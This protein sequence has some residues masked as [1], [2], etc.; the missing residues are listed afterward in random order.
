MAWRDTRASRR[1]LLLFSTSIVMGIAA[2][3]AIRSFAVSAERAI[4]EQSRLLLGA[5]LS[6]TS[7][8][9]L[10]A[11]D[12]QLLASLGGEQAREIDFSAMLYFP[13][14]AGAQAGV[15][16]VQV[17][18]SST[19]YPFYGQF[20]AEPEGAVRAFR[21][22][23]GVLLEPSLLHQFN[24]R[25]GDAVRLGELTTR[26]A[27]TIKR[28]PGE[29]AA[30]AALAPRV[31]VSTNLVAETGLLRDGSI[32]RYKAYF[33]FPEGTKVREMVANVRPELR[34]H[35][36]NFHTVETRKADLGRS[37]DNVSNY[38]H[39]AAL[40]ALLLGGIGVASGIHVHVKAKLET[41]AVL[42][43]LGC[44]VGQ[45]FAIYLCQALLV[46]L[47]GALAGAAAGVLLQHAVPLAVGGFFPVK[48]EVA[49]DWAGVALAITQGLA[50]AILFALLPLL[51]VRRVSPLAAIR[52]NY[53]PARP[54]HH[55]WTVWVIYAVMTAAVVLF[56]IQHSRGWKQ[57]LQFAGGLATAFLV[58]A[59]VARAIVWVARRFSFRR[60]PYVWRQGFANLHRPQN[61]TTLLV[62]SLGLGTFLILSIFLVQNSLVKELISARGRNAP[63]L[64]LFD[65][66]TDQRDG[67][68]EILRTNSV[69]V[70]D[71]SP[72]VTMR[73][74]GIKGQTAEE[75]LTETNRSIPGWALRREYRSTYTD[76]LRPGE[77]L[78]AGRWPAA[79]VADTPTPISIEKRI[80]EELGV[81]LGDAM[82]FD[83]QGVPMETRIVAIREVDWRRVQPNFFVV[84]APEALREAPA[85]HIVTARVNSAA[86]SAQIQ[87]TIVETFANVSAIDLMLILQTLDGVFTRISV[88]V[89]FMASFII[90]TGLLVLIGTILTGR[91]QRIRESVL[92]RS[93][94]AS[95]WQVLQV[96]LAEHL[97]LG[98]L[99]A[100]VGALL[101]SGA[102][103]ALTRFVFQ[104]AFVPAVAP[105]VWAV[106]LVPSV[107][108]GI[109][110]LA[111]RGILN[112]PPLAV[113][114]SE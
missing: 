69:P 3:V 62:L 79:S 28:A 106:V 47:L 22:G 49:T 53:Q 17:R 72:V 10:T 86:Q 26:I 6:V 67:V 107:S 109:G 46:G 54:L 101:A 82:T 11:E 84:F 1:R 43:C 29:S 41:A 96:L 51:D 18:A 35:R 60:L 39:L 8:R 21:A 61:R 66:Q 13:K 112:H 58:L 9:A 5:D 37:V 71:E 73:L 59:L 63:N 36:L 33:K 40:I 2:L 92:L 103:W 90:G 15:R 52:A 114:R 12:E 45:T 99:A 14:E 7:R 93:L 113:L 20:E 64:A 38:L 83:V 31:Y 98:L 19:N 30:L 105:L 76:A 56:C 42:R 74:G 25:I 88:A 48:I 27:G 81:S 87:R 91:Y 16:L 108:V 32:A 80:A 57:G 44:S 70:L 97:A 75:L 100:L 95:R 94:G 85:S 55:D 111:S 89:Q 50:S 68:L 78:L 23:T 34:E 102:G 77:K 4:D 24:A 110:L 104:T 65:I